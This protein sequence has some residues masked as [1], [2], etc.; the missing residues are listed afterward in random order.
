MELTVA[1][2]RTHVQTACPTSSNSSSP[3]SPQ[4]APPFIPPFILIHGAA[5]DSDA[6]MNVARGLVAAGHTVHVPDLP[7]HGRSA[8][9]PL[10]SI[11]ELADWL[12]A[13]LDGLKVE[14]AILAGHSMGSLIALE[15]AAR[16][17][18]RVHRLALLG[19]TI[20]MPVSEALLDAAQNKPD[21]ACRMIMKFSHTPQFFLNGGGG[22]GVWG[23]GV[24]LAIMRRAAPGVLATDLGNC[25]RYLR[26]QEAAASVAKS[27]CP[28]LM[29]VAKR[30]RMTPGRNVQALASALGN[31]SR[32]EIAD[33]GHAMMNERPQEI[34]A[35][36]HRFAS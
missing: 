4:T 21:A 18:Q 27:A 11:E 3:V 26:G 19:S 5:N 34:S 8:G 10:E 29:I 2:F 23:P 24:T 16:H 33:C 31:P 36:L 15:A 22:H 9:S 1:G 28:T 32:C 6:W 12:I 7:G 14:K 20:P 30:D 13:L 35:A 25:N 17:P